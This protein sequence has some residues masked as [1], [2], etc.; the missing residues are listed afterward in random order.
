MQTRPERK[1]AAEH[2]RLI[3]RTAESL[4]SEYGVGEVSM[5]QI[6]KSAGIGQG[7]LYRKYA[8]KGE[9]CL[10][11]LIEY[12]RDFLDSVREYLAEHREEPAEQRLGWLLDSWIELIETHS[13]LILSIQSHLHQEKVTAKSGNFFDS[14]LFRCFREQISS[15][16][17]EISAREPGLRQDPQLAAHSLICAMLPLGYYHLKK[18]FGRTTRQMKN[19]FRL[20]CRL[21]A[22]DED[23]TPL[24]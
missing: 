5:H 23:L 11:I 24:G 12:S 16:L 20:M 4:F 18:E 3:L 15:L 10:E 2:R 19:H 21:P 14:E 13:E 17:A 7:T 22:L 8:H 1:D 6:A 9:L